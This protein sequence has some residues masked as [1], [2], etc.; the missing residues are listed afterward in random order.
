ML[1]PEPTIG[2]VWNAN[3]GALTVRVRVYGREA[4]VGLLHQGRNAFEDAVRVVRA[5]SVWHGGLD[6]VAPAFT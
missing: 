2:V 1:T 6:G 5:C 3:R 4:H